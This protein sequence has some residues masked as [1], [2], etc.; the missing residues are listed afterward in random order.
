MGL[1]H[2]NYSS[3]DELLEERKIMSKS[4]RSRKSV[5]TPFTI[6]TESITIDSAFSEI[7]ISDDSDLTDEGRFSRALQSWMTD[8]VIVPIEPDNKPRREIVYS[9]R[10][11]KR[12]NL[13]RVP[14]EESIETKISLL[15]CS[16]GETSPATR[17]STSVKGRRKKRVGGSRAQSAMSRDSGAA[18]QREHTWE[19]F[20]RKT[21]D[22]M[23]DKMMKSHNAVQIDMVAGFDDGESEAFHMMDKDEQEALF[24][25]GSTLGVKLTSNLE[26]S[27]SASN[28]N[29]NQYIRQKT[30]LKRTLSAGA[31]PQSKPINLEEI[32]QQRLKEKM[33]LLQKHKLRR[34]DRSRR[35]IVSQ[36]SSQFS[37]RSSVLS[38]VAPNTPSVRS[39]SPESTGEPVQ[40]WKGDREILEMDLRAGFT[41]R[42]QK[43]ITA[44]SNAINRATGLGD[45]NSMQRVIGR[46]EEFPHLVEE[47]YA[48]VPKIVQRIKISP[49]LSN[50]IKDDIKVRMGRPRYHEIKVKDLE[51]WNKSMRLDRSHTNLK[52]FNWLHSLREDDF[53]KDI[54]PYIQDT[55]PSSEDDVENVHV[56]AADER[57]VKP[58][59]LK[60]F[61]LLKPQ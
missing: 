21:G 15:S 29:K 36:F 8:Y 58:L 3:V 39:L 31:T 42:V 9:G 6:G 13:Q 5:A 51:Q 35:S 14:S 16:S 37:S 60:K 48:F 47:D 53:D 23:F 32:R 30:R 61:D 2:E 25:S 12:P 38:D 17:P 56:E 1:L 43:K 26:R 7:S 20:A 59:Y 4:A 18:P 57:D 49:Q 22:R 44:T 50:V 28:V 45:N 34:R 27:D 11:G 52:V 10:L 19:Y 55:I 24:K 33:A 41:E 40:M 54:E 46:H